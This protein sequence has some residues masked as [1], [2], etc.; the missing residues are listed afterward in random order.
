M[1]SLHLRSAK[2]QPFPVTQQFAKLVRVEPDYDA[3][4]A[5]AAL[6]WAHSGARGVTMLTL[7]ARYNDIRF[8]SAGIATGAR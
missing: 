6:N 1:F 7:R 5:A 2:R 8:A 3:S 4:A